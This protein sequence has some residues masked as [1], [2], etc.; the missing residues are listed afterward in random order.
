MLPWQYIKHCVK[1]DFFFVVKIINHG[2]IQHLTNLK[3]SWQLPRQS[4]TESIHFPLCWLQN[5]RLVLFALRYDLWG[6]GPDWKESHV[7]WLLQVHKISLKREDSYRINHVRHDF[8]LGVN[9]HLLRS[10]PLQLMPFKPKY[11]LCK[12]S[13]TRST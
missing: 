1:D 5:A 11:I 2:D 6:L 7:D 4:V 12:K 13:I 3:S 9:K 8:I 10:I